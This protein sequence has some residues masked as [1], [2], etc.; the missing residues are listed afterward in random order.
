MHAVRAKL[1]TGPRHENGTLKADSYSKNKKRNLDCGAGIGR[2][3]KNYILKVFQKADLVEQ[4]P[5][6]LQAAEAS[7]L[8]EE[9]A[10]GCVG[11]FYPVGLQDFYP[12]PGRYDMI[13][14]QWV[15]GHLTDDDL[16]AFFVR[17]KAALKPNGFLGVKEN[18]CARNTVELDD[19]DS[20]VTR[21]AVLLESIFERAGLTVMK[22][23]VQKGFPKG[24]FP[25][26]MYILR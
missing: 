11:V 3:S 9:V 20:S 23:E 18:V 16:I 25:V 10:A 22:K 7:Y 5:N 1:W 2:V 21:P 13:W 24:L 8:K 12:T 6:F 26:N 19:D 15:L 14:S 17:C 4:N